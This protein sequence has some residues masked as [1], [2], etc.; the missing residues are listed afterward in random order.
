MFAQDEAH[1]QAGQQLQVKLMRGFQVAQRHLRA[2][3]DEV[4]GQRRALPCAS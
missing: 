3:G 1:G 4:T 2:L